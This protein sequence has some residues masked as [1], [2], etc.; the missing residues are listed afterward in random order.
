MRHASP[1]T[2]RD[3]IDV[4]TV[5][6]H[7]FPVIEAAYL[8]VFRHFGGQEK[9]MVIAGCAQRNDNSSRWVHSLTM[10][11]RNLGFRFNLDGEILS[12]LPESERPQKRF[13]L[14]L[15]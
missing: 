9:E 12:E 11:A 4:R 2:L 13:E 10:R 7:S 15:H 6:F 5:L 14:Q 8:R 1:Q 3:A